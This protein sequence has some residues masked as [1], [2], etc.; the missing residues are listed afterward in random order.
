ME[1]QFVD[2]HEMIFIGIVGC[3]SDVSQLDICG[4]WERFNEH[5]QNIKHQIEGKNY[6]L[7]IQEETLPSMHFCLAGVQVQ[8]IEDMPIELFAKVIPPCRYAVF[9]HHFRDGGFNFAFK[10]VYDW[11][12]ESEYT[13]AY[14]FDIQCYDERF[15]GPDSP[16]SI[17]E[18]YVPIASQQG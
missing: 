10:A 9:T 8:K 5:S 14:P 11:L 1:P 15:K 2:K 4:L 12:K 18:I 13:A 7:H 3:S 17:L 16:E 6:E